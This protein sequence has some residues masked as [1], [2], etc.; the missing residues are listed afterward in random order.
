MVGVQVGL[1]GVKLLSEDGGRALRIYPLN[2]ISRWALRDT[3][4][5]LYTKTPVDVEE[6]AV[7][8]Q[9]P[10]NVTQSVLDT[11]TCSCMQ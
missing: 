8:L 5:V 3:Q 1:E 11:L 2:H 10:K 6:R 7:T 9:A 4:L